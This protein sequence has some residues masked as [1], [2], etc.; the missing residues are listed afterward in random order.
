M[1]ERRAR[2]GF[3]YQD[4]VA[5]ERILT[6]LR[7]DLHDGTK[8]FEGVRLADL[9]AGRV[10]DFVLVWKESVEG[11][12]IK[13]SAR[14]TEFT[15]GELVGAS[16]LLRDL[17][18]GWNR[19]RS[20]WTG[21]TVTVRIHTNRPASPAKHHAQIIPS[22]SLAEFVETY[23]A[24]GPD[25]ANTI[26]ASEAWRKIAEHVSLS[27]SEL[28][29]FVAHCELAFGQ[30]EPPSAGS[31]SLDSRHYR[32]SSTV[33]TRLLPRGSRTILTVVSSNGTT[34]LRRSDCDRAVPA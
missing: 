19:L 1:G 8:A 24:S 15:W 34:S 31:D 33:F 5:T 2:W 14:A 28:S 6:F 27:G 29:D 7:T 12:S 17:A 4:K 32:N 26:E 20:H 22:F 13:W 21:R 9:D 10:D 23:W 25:A 16:G 11:N 3:G 30:A 18:N